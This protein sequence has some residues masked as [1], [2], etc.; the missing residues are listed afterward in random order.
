[1]EIKG[2][3]SSRSFPFWRVTRSETMHFIYF[4]LRLLHFPSDILY[5]QIYWTGLNNSRHSI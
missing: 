3:N 5:K 4:L 2:E 1:M